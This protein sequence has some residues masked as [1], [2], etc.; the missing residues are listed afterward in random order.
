MIIRPPIEIQPCG[1]GKKYCAWTKGEG[2]NARRT[3]CGW[4]TIFVGYCGLFEAP[5]F[6][7]DRNRVLRCP[8]CVQAQKETES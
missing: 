2:L 8:Q 3:Q 5:C 7:D 6:R 1:P 4:Y